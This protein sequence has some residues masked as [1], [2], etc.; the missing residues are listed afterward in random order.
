[1]SLSEIEADR[2]LEGDIGG[3]I[4]ALLDRRAR[5]VVIVL[6]RVGVPLGGPMV[7]TV[8]RAALGVKGDP[9]ARGGDAR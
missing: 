1:M 7:P 3:G 9:G 2:W 6:G 8:V 4:D 5:G